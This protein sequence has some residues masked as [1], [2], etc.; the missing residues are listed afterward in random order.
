MMHEVKRTQDNVHIVA[1]KSIYVPLWLAEKKSI[2]CF[3][4]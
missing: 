4:S 2:T 3:N 1:K